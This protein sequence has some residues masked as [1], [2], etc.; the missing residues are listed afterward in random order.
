[1]SPTEKIAQRTQTAFILTRILGLPLWG[2]ISLLTFI[3]YKHSL[4]TPLQ[5]A[6]I[7]ALKPM[8]SLLAPYWSQAIYQRQ[9]RITSNLVWANIFRYLPFLLLPWVN[10]SWFIIFIFGAYMMLYRATVPAWLEL[11]KCHLPKMTRER[12]V[13]LGCTIDYCGTA[14][15]TLIL[16]ILLDNFEEGWY[17]LFFAT[18]LIGFS[19]TW[20]LFFLPSPAVTEPPLVKAFPATSF[21]GYSFKE[22]ILKPWSQ[23][24]KLIREC[25]D[26]ASFQIGFMF[27]GAGLMIMQPALP[28]F[29]VDTLNLSYTEL[30]IALAMCKGIGVA[31][32]SPVW[33]RLFGKLSIFHFCSLV[34]FLAAIFPFFLLS[35]SLS[36]VLLYLA[37]ILYGIMQAGSELSWHM[38]GLLFSKEKESSAYSSTNVLTV[39][40]RGCIVPALGSAILMSS[41][42]ISVMILGGCLCF[43]GTLHF[44]RYSR[45]KA[46]QIQDKAVML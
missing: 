22:A 30:S 28:A 39:G 44:L 36:I 25:P 29:F 5:I 9:D 43:L 20:F 21:I 8:S 31:V 6:I 11:F 12:T 46:K 45:N 23:S 4:I 15:L 33:T 10:N 40:I 14:I 27:G 42:S 17:W 16:G 18:A 2:L 38:S 1:M 7:I 19:S 37:Y 32:S 13:A 3:L 34:T 35:S 24:W 41:S 26:F